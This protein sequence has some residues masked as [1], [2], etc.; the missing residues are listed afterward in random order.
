[1]R[2]QIGWP[3][4]CKKFGSRQE[5]EYTNYLVHEIQDL[6]STL[7]KTVGIKSFEEEKGQIQ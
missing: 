1:M 2:S 4:T 3:G 6:E 5:E 7:L